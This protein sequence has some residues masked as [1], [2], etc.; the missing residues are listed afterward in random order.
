[1]A[2]TNPLIWGWEQMRLSAANL[3]AAGLNAA[4]RPA[5][6][7]RDLAIRPVGIADLRKALALG[8]QDFA[9]TRTDVLTLCV[10]YPLLGL[11]FAG[12]ASGA[13]MLPLVFP[14]ASGFALLAPVA[15]LGL[16]ELSRRRERGL[17]AGWTDMF[18]VLRSPA[19]GQITLLALL[20]A[21]LYGLW[22]ATAGLIYDRTL[23]PQPPLSWS[24]FATDLVATPMGWTMIGL[25]L[26]A[27]FLFAALVL[28]ISVVSFPLMLD[29]NVSLNTAMA[30]SARAVMANKAAMAVWGLILATG[31][32]AGSVPLLLGLAVVLPVLGHASWH[33]YRLMI[34]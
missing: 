4:S 18:A 31:L 19:I 27:G 11:A 32:L 25:G 6:L 26:C 23:G 17:S 20:L 24:S 15:A 30:V 12:L 16:Y 21:G 10:L 13:G 5:P 2:I 1:M 22:L 3:G 29:R 34:R 33:L 7:S 8:L 9:A 28:T 14:L